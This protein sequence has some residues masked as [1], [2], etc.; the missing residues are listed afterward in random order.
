MK[1]QT[2]SQTAAST[3]H[4]QY[5]E[6]LETLTAILLANKFAAEKAKQ[7]AEIFTINSFE[8]RS[9]HGVNRFSRFIHHVQQQKV[10]ADAVPECVHSSGS[11]EQWDGRLGPGPLNAL[12]CTHRAME[13]A[14]MHTIGCVGL[15][16]TNHW[17][18]AGYYAGAA[19]KEGFIFIGWT[20][21]T[22][23]MPAWGGISPVLGNNPLAVG[24]PF[25]P[26]PVVLDMAMSQFSYGTM[27]QASAHGALL[28]FPGGFTKDGALTNDPV[29]ILDSGRPLPIGMWKGSGL[30][31]VLDILAAAIS[32]GLPTQKISARDVEYGVSQVF[33]A[34]HIPSID[35]Q[36]RFAA[37]VKES[38]EGILQSLPAD[39]E[40]PVRYPGATT[41]LL[42]KKNMESGVP[43][44]ASVW[45]E[46]INLL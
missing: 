32:G 31:F 10:I 19:A 4:I 30:A 26:E 2:H 8:G 16:H 21:T 17:M 5:Q 7:C 23:I 18:R 42:R 11:F 20:N 35:T 34:L 28:P 39:P 1:K 12:L 24:I 29:E 45:Q 41:G 22:G 25:Q 13:L 44:N 6:M 38:V 3:I 15:A 46:I 40:H 27:E 36:H 9:S 37:V 43:V 14:R 33:I